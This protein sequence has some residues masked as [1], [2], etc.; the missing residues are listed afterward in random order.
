MSLFLHSYL[1]TF[2]RIYWSD[3]IPFGWY[4]HDVWQYQWGNNWATDMCIDWFEYDGRRE[5]FYMFL[6][7][8][9]ACP[10]TMDQATA[11]VGRFVALMDCDIGG[12]HRCYYTQGA[13]HCVVSTTSV[14]DTGEKEIHLSEPC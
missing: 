10:C 14:Y 3:M 7:N 2:L 6:E 11:D 13:Q 5:N 4:F 9:H 12:D 8:T 1:L